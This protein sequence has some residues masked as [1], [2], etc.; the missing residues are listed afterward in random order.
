M[1]MRQTSF[2]FLLFGLLALLA[3]CGG[4]KNSDDSLSQAPTKSVEGVQAGQNK[5]Q[6]AWD[7]EVK[8]NPSGLRLTYLNKN[9]TVALGR[10]NLISES[11]EDI[12]V[13]ES[14]SLY[15]KKSIRTQSISPLLRDSQKLEIQLASSFL[16]KCYEA[17]S[18]DP[19]RALELLDE[20]NELLVTAAGTFQSRYLKYR[21]KGE[22]GRFDEGTVETW[23][24][25]DQQIPLLL[26]SITT[27]NLNSS[28]RNM[29]QIKSQVLIN[30]AWP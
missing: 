9:L 13:I 16:K 30:L 27:L 26:K 17:E 15:I 6:K 12:E 20:K 4:Q 29:T 2:Y 18:Q 5:C 3:S 23:S 1:K 11:E 7:L 21:L 19:S 22:L 8:N 10:E 28:G 25:L 24:S 14:D